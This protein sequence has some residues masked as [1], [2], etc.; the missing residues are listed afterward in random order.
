MAASRKLFDLKR[1]SLGRQLTMLA[2]ITGGIA[3]TF[4]ATGLIAYEV[5]WFRSQLASTAS[6]TADILGSNT[7]AALAFENQSD[8]KQ[9][10]SALVSDKSVARA[11][12]F[13]AS[14]QLFADYERSAEAIGSGVPKTL[15]DALKGSTGLFVVRPIRLDHEIVG[16]I[17]V[18]SD[19][20]PLYARTLV[21]SS[22]TLLV[23][24]VSLAFA[25]PATRRMQAAICSPL[26]RLEAAARHVSD[27]RDY[28]A[29]ISSD[30]LSSNEVDAL[31]DA[32]N[33]MLQQIQNRDQRLSEWAEQLESQ[34]QTRTQSLVEANAD[35]S[36]AKVKAEMAVRAKSEFLANMSHEIRT[37][38]NG[39][40][41]MTELALDTDCHRRAA[42]VP[43][44]GQD[45]RLTPCCTI[46]NDILDFSKIE[47]RK[48]HSRK[49]RV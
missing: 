25:F 27:H 39:I 8:V 31:I 3:V 11:Y 37:P 44:H 19:L 4:T 32:F 23:A 9:S 35:L 21:Y 15:D 33:E 6:S 38:M 43:R 10:L 40:I 14:R 1:M 17:G 47:A 12:V 2:L 34:V 29:R 46:I 45:R 5:F 48:V 16:F 41:G 42:G 18:E 49:Q 36:A 22:I 30:S 13:T 26:L 28:T 7:A 20:S 24:L